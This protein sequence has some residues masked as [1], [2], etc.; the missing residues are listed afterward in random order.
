MGT[1][2]PG[3]PGFIVI[4][5]NVKGKFMWWELANGW[6]VWSTYGM[7]GQWVFDAQGGTPKHAVVSFYLALPAADFGDYHDTLHFKDPR[8]FGTVKFS[9]GREALDAKLATLGPDMLASPP[10]MIEFRQIIRRKGARTLAEAVMD[11]HTICGVG[12]YIKAEAL[13]LARLSPHRK[14]ESLTDTDADRLRDSIVDVMQRSYMSKGTSVY[15][16][17]NVDG[18]RGSFADQLCVYG[19]AMAHGHKVVKEETLDG[20]MTHWVPSVQ[21]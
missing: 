12:N 20:R 19:K 10:G 6:Y 2:N 16:Y 3:T 21:V 7:S 1:Y 9:R 15:S 13:Y 4:D 11:Q 17:S 14:C 18:T 5:V 8:H